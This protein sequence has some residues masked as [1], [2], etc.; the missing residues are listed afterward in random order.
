MYRDEWAP[1]AAT[2]YRE[3]PKRLQARIDEA[4]LDVCADPLR[5]RNVK[6]LKGPLKGKYRRRVGDWRLIYA[7]EHDTKIVRVLAL[8]DRRDA[9]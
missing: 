8:T 1:D 7:L 2:I 5:A 6:A 9:Y 3:L 4:I